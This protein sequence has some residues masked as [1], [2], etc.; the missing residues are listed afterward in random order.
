MFKFASTKRIEDL[1]AWIKTLT[2]GVQSLEAKVADRDDLIA[3]ITD[4]SIELEEEIE[5]WKTKSLKDMEKLGQCLAAFEGIQ[6]I[7]KA[8]ES[9][10]NPRGPRNN[11][12]IGAKSTAAYDDELRKWKESAQKDMDK[13]EKLDKWSTRY[14]HESHT[15]MI[16]KPLDGSG[17]E[18]TPMKDDMPV[19]PEFQKWMEDRR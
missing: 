4:E 5:R 10:V 7:T 17:D 2:E 12:A 15:H 16:S 8:V 11:V 1:E 19:N 13:A 6:T 18:S 3:K 9:K 14:D